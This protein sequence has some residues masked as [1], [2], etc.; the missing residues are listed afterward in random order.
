MWFR[1]SFQRMKQALSS[2]HEGTSSY[3]LLDDS[4]YRLL[5]VPQKNEEAQPPE[6]YKTSSG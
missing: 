5:Y 3:D 6:S 4:E 2:W 1:E